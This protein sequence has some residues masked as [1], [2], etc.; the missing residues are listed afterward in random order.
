MV[1]GNAM[2]EKASLA[3]LSVLRPSLSLSHPA[4]TSMSHPPPLSL[5]LSL[6]LLSLV[7]PLTLSLPLPPPSIR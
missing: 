1:L 6:P 4:I 5:A 7:H 3:A 2:A